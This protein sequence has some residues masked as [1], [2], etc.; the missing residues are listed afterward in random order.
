M[1]TFFKGISPAQWIML[2]CL[3]AISS[4]MLL[5]TDAHALTFRKPMS[6]RGTTISHCGW[7][8]AD[9]TLYTHNVRNVRIIQRKLS[10]LGYDLGRSGIDGK[11][12][13]KT[14]A[15]ISAFQSDHGLHADGAAGRE[16]VSVLAY[17]THPLQN[18]RRCKRP[19][20]G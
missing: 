7:L 11:I 15:A 16:T 13:P 17:S 19:Y 20:M 6:P 2:G 10:G 3:L 1:I 9:D 4:L 8:Q 5:A 18:V 14:R 12:G